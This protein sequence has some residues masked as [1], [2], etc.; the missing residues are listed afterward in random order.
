MRQYRVIV[1]AIVCVLLILMTPKCIFGQ[2]SNSQSLNRINYGIKFQFI[3]E[4]FPVA[5]VWRHTFAIP[6]PQ[7]Q[8]KDAEQSMWLSKAKEQ[9][10]EPKCTN[11][12]SLF[13]T[14]T[15]YVA[16]IKHLVSK[17]LDSRRRINDL[18]KDIRALLP[19]PASMFS[20]SRKRAL[21][22]FV[23]GWLNSLFGVS[24][25]SDV[26]Q[27]KA[28]VNSIGKS[29]EKTTN[30]IQKVM[31]DMS[32]Y[33]KV[34]NTR[35]DD[36][37]SEIRETTQA[38]LQMFENAVN[39]VSSSLIYVMDLM[40]KSS[41][42]QYKSF[43]LEN[44]FTNYLTA[45]E[46]LILGKLPSYIVPPQFIE[47]SIAEIEDLLQKKQYK[48][49]YNEANWYYRSGQF[50]FSTDSNYLYI[51]LKYPLT[52]FR[53]NFQIFKLHLYDL[54][55]HG[56]N[57]H[58]TKLENMPYAIAISR[59]EEL[60]Q[61][62]NKETVDRMVFS[63]EIEW[64]RIFIKLK[65]ESCLAALYYGNK[66]N[67]NKNCKYTMVTNA[68]STNMY[69]LKGAT[70]MFQSVGKYKISCNGND[71]LHAGCSACE[72]EIPQNCSLDS[73]DHFIAPTLIP[74]TE[75]PVKEA[76]VGHITNIPFLK[77][78]FPNNTQIDEIMADVLLAKEPNIT[79]PN[80]KFYEHDVM[81][82]IAANNQTKLDLDKASRAL[83]D[84]SLVIQGMAD[85]L[86]I[87]EIPVDFSGWSFWLSAPGFVIETCFAGLVLLTIHSIYINH[88]LR[89][90][91]LILTLMQNKIT[92]VSTQELHLNYFSKG[93]Q[94]MIEKTQ[95]LSF[96]AFL[97]N[98][99]PNRGLYA[100]VMILIAAL[101]LMIAYKIWKKVNPGIEVNT[102]FDMALEFGSSK[103]TV[104]IPIKKFHGHPDDYSITA[105]IYLHQA[106]VIGVLTPVLILAGDNPIILDKISGHEITM[107][108]RFNLTWYQAWKLRKIMNKPYSLSLAFIGKHFFSRV[109][110]TRAVVSSVGTM[111]GSQG[112]APNWQYPQPP[113]APIPNQLYP[114]L[115]GSA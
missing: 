31:S 102:R 1:P 33:A 106:T 30:A 3:T 38:N 108:S 76:I 40:H 24:T 28:H 2:I 111:S 10:K 69:E 46:M 29:V 60:Y 36:L 100:I 19:K 105:N 109:N 35:M 59:Q 113:S 75:N 43:A 72:I 101:L 90:M 85:A 27:L 20:E 41:E 49:I 81:E 6:L 95:G 84:D 114:N 9:I 15:N 82:K 107:P 22:P 8:E 80:F 11:N 77:K 104:F 73:D 97:E 93:E 18:N 16:E 67:I 17:T 14:C 86:A 91:A 79:L 74:S 42:L 99:V 64:N 58:V 39:D 89:E 12:P 61:E 62:L 23:G 87:G 71:S 65:E 53:N 103:D 51:T 32:S 63:G 98:N 26:N 110:V 47:S 13:P 70:F 88:R 50:L 112:Q 68:K 78:L 92:G 48:L 4:K 7:V 52:T 5:S 25:E 94:T 34:M 96:F 57:S 55:M 54:P 45:V 83:Q 44:H 115:H 21:L 37:S 66:N 56:D